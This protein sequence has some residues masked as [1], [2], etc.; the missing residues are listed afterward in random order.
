MG[1]SIAVAADLSSRKDRSMRTMP[2]K[3]YID[4]AQAM[5]CFHAVAG[6]AAGART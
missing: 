2:L 4:A 1:Y 5:Q 6:Q 3:S